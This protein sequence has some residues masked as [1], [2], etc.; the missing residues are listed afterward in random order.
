MHGL[1]AD[2]AL[3]FELNCG[4][5]TPEPKKATAVDCRAA[6]TRTGVLLARRAAVASFVLTVQC[7]P[8][9]STE[10]LAR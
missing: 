7:L 5:K 9:A 10:D 2:Y 6:V 8:S 1:R 4:N 3:E